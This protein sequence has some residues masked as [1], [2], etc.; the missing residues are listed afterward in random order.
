MKHLYEQADAAQGTFVLLHGTGGNETSLLAIARD[1]A[2]DRN[3][4]GIR[5]EVEENGMP[6]YFR[7]LSEGVFD[8]E[9]LRFRTK[10]LADFIRE[11]AEKYQFSL[12]TTYLV[13]YSNGANI[14]AN[15]MLQESNF[16]Q[17]AILLHPMVPSREKNDLSLKGKQVFISAGTL[18]PLVANEEVEELYHIMQ[19]KQA[20]V[21]LHWEE[22]GHGVSRSEIE[23]AKNWLVHHMNG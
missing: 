1:L 21:H 8:M 2:P 11:A 14:A 12:D 7:R 20:T 5:G 10:Q 17:G 4:L 16:V 23:A 9:D 22:N 18:D 3:M 15:M 19:Q 13:G 6:R